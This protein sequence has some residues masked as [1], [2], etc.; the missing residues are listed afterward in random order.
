VSD[1][2]W[3]AWRRLSPVRLSRDE[4]VAWMG[5]PMGKRALK[6]SAVSLISIAVSQV[7]LFLTFGIARIGS[8]VECNVIATAVATIPS[9]NLN[10][11]WAW[12][13]SGT[14]HVWREVVPFWVIAF[15]GLAFSLVAVALADRVGKSLNLSHLSISL[16]VN[17]ASLA[18]Y[19]LLWVGKFLVFN[20]FLFVDHH[21]QL[22]LVGSGGAADAT[23]AGPIDSGR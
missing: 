21:P 20:R 10:R 2:L 18:S 6:Y 8:A 1:A 19:G 3:R 15:V 23:G 13:K 11:R 9:Y 12:G 4:I 5:T 16:L 7:V 14:S 17:A 22:E